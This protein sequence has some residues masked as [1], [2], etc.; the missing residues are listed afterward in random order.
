MSKILETL[1]P[2]L[3][4]LLLS[5]IFLMS[6]IHKLTAWSQTARQM[7]SE[8]MAAVPLFL[9]GAILCEVLGGLLLLLGCWA[10]LGALI[11]I[12]FLIPTT[13]IFHDFWTYA[14]E[15]Q[16]TQMINFLK[17]LA[18]LGGLLMVFAYG[19]GGISLDARSR[20]KRAKESS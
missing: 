5:A 9:V 3:G 17:N 2:P 12:V 19:A 1:V 11:L 7:E 14:G 10:R 15:E 16:Q 13:L 18:I 6:G 8:G 4:R 20:R